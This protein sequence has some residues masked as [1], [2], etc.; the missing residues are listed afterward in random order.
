MS[1]RVEIYLYCDNECGTASDNDIWGKPGRE[2][3]SLRELR[4]WCKE[5][6]WTRKKNLITGKYEDF[7]PECSESG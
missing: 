6:G 7:C 1:I 2:K 5:E 4:R 3:L